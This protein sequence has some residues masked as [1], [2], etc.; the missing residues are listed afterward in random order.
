MRVWAFPA[1][2]ALIGG[3]CGRLCAQQAGGTFTGTVMDGTGSVVPSAAVTLIRLDSGN[4][5][6]TRTNSAGYFTFSFVPASEYALA[7]DATGFQRW[8]RSGIIISPG[9]K[10]DAGS[11]VLQIVGR[12]QSVTV[13][14]QSDLISTVDSG[15]KASVITRADLDEAPVL[16]R[17]AGELV[18]LLPGISPTGSAGAGVENHAGFEGETISI[19]A[20]PTSSYSANGTS[21]HSMFVTS[22][23]VDVSD[24]GF[25]LGSP[26]NPNIDMVQEVKVLQSNF[27]AENAKGPSVL[28]SITKSGGK[29]FHA[30]AYVNARHFALN[31]N[32]WLL[33]KTGQPRPESKYFFPGANIGGP[34][35]IPGTTFNRNREKLFFFA[36]FEYFK[37]TLDNGVLRSIVPSAAMRAGD[38]RDVAYLQA[39]AS[40][41]VSA[42][43]AEAFAPGGLIPKSDIDPGGR[44]LMNLI[45]SPNVDPGSAGAGSNYIK[46]DLVD[47]HM[48][49]FV[50]RLDSN[51]SDYTKLFLRYS[52]QRQ[53]QSFTVGLWGRGP[54]Q[55]RY[56]TDTEV[57]THSDSVAA[58]VVQVLSPS[59]TNEL[60]FGL[61]NMDV[62]VTLE[63]PAKVSRTAL[64]YPYQGMFRNGEDQV[65]F[66]LNFG[67]AAQLQTLPFGL[68]FF[69]RTWQPMAAENVAKVA[70]THTLKVGAHW[71]WSAN[72]Q[73]STD[74]SN[75]ILAY[76]TWG[77]NSTGN[78]YADL[79]TGRVADYYESN[80]NIVLDL[81]YQTFEA[82]AQ[83][84][85]KVRPRLTIEYGIRLSH[86]GAWYDRQGIGYG[87]FDPSKYSDDPSQLG[88]SPGLVWH[89]QDPSVPLS[90]MSTRTLFY[91]PRVGAAFDI[92]GTGR[93]VL[94]GGFGVYRYHDSAAQYSE[95]LSGPA[96]HRIANV[97]HATTLR[98]IDS[99]QPANV[100]SALDTLDPADDHQPVTYAYS[101]TVSQ[102]I[103]KSTLWETGYVG[104]QSRD[105]YNAGVYT[106]INRVPLGAMLSDPYGNADDY[107]PLRNYQGVRIGEHNLYANYNSLQTTLRRRQGLFTYS[108]AYTFSKTMG[109]RGV[110]DLGY[111][112]NPF[113]VRDN[114]GPLAYDRTHLLSLLYIASLPEFHSGRLLPALANGWKIAGIS[115]VGSGLNLQAAGSV[116]FNVTGYL[117]D[118]ET[119]ISNTVIAGTPDVILQPVLTCNPGSHLRQNQFING[120]CFGVPAPGYNGAYLFPYLKGPPFWNNDLSISRALQ[121]SE[122]KRVEL[123]VSAFNFLNHPLRSFQNGDP[124]LYLSFDQNGKLDN[125]RFGYADTKF[126][127]RA[128]QLTVKFI[129]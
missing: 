93:T 42:P 82:Y 127:H 95:T 25:Y 120:S 121:L 114:Y 10:R 76:A 66:I 6:V 123:R 97:G 86:L 128:V 96:G 8:K 52:L 63:D 35:L 62:P 112:A 115:E 22:D 107:R 70:G 45:P 122:R 83:D 33:N 16:S 89:Q 53:L 67:G 105:L 77:G 41:E 40:P 7:V 21:T 18:R 1:L 103:G 34:V 60:V 2:A 99:L 57:H 102:R 65:P 81:A 43:P 104:N 110:N 5:R 84:S 79:L 47:E 37:E 113:N 56:P 54:S 19:A 17:N 26:V 3:L 125:P 46:P 111:A 49:Q 85:W 32:E 94:R 100:R 88:K 24:P 14:A 72:A 27:S 108:A 74:N 61:T 39:L 20:G 75:G 90:G 92:S 31:S 48:D 91:E 59:F 119:P 69:S 23:G 101:F 71:E 13:S 28:Q 126:G 50:G 9:D 129:F 55:V 36:G 38:F 12:P 124:N 109:V 30:E 118:S 64:G 116:N 80:R 58:S 4:T 106:D 11:I 98:E 87:V 73:P 117:P 51:I 78:A 44:V 68:G 15:E 29:D